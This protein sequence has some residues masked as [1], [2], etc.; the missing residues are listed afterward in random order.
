V[1]SAHD[2]PNH[3]NV[4]NAAGLEVCEYQYYDAENHTLDFEGL[5]APFHAGLSGKEIRRNAQRTS[6]ARGLCCPRTTGGN[7]RHQKL[8]Q[9]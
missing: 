5:L 4:F 8:S 1:L 9:H 3:K 7:Q 6:T 2:R